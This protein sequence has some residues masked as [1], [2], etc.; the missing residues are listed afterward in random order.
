MCIKLRL[1]RILQGQSTVRYE[2]GTQN[3][4]DWRLQMSLWDSFTNIKAKVYSGGFIQCT[5]FP[6]DRISH[7]ILITIFCKNHMLVEILCFNL[8]LAVFT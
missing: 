5:V 7:S 6:E 1:Y 2:L 3:V 8:F 4:Q